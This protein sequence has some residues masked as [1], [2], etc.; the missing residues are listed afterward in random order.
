MTLMIVGRIH[1]PEFDVRGGQFA[2]LE[3]QLIGSVSCRFVEAG[4]FEVARLGCCS[5]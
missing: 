3:M 1:L 2:E 5:G 4:C